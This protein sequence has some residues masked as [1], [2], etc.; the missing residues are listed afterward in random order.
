MHEKHEMREWIRFE[1]VSK[2]IGGKCVLDD[3]HLSIGEGSVYGVVGANGAGKT[4]LLRLI[5]GLYRPTSGNISVF[6]EH[7]PKEA[8]P[9]RQRIHL[10][11]ADGAFYAGFRVRDHLRYASM[12]YERYDQRRAHQLIDALELP[13]NQPIRALSLG[14]KMQLR[15][16]VALASRPD[17]L[18]LDEATNGLD[19][20][21]RQQFL[22]L[23]VDETASAGTTVVMATHRLEDLEPLADHASILY[24]GRLIV[25]G[26]L[27]DLRAEFHEVMA[28]LTTDEPIQPDL[29]PQHET[30]Q[31]R[32]KIITCVVRGEVKPIIQALQQQGAVHVDVQAMG[33]ESLFRALLEKEG[34]TRD[35]ILLS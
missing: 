27:D 23:I 26:A 15:L 9:L 14:M 28:V 21:V 34:Y 1:H 30:I 31:Q 35:T 33:F 29:L 12:L 32:G 16:A 13:L 3:I 19:P 8:A 10:V 20:I 2:N 4:T 17:I 25:A 18:L 11:S 5:N 6:G 24:K 22:Q 7:L